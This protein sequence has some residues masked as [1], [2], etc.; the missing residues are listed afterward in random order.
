MKKR[1][2]SDSSTGAKKN[3]LKVLYSEETLQKALA[4]IKNGMS[5]KF[6]SKF[7][8][9]PRSTLQ[10]RMSTKFKKIT[11]APDPYLTD[12]ED[13]LVSWIIDSHKKGFPSN[14]NRRKFN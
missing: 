14:F 12:E 3:K 7:Y 6:A 11:R 5:K 2:L 9:I 8:G 10:F 13:L 4:E 1:K